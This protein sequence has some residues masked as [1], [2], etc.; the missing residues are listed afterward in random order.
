MIVSFSDI[1]LEDFDEIAGTYL[2]YKIFFSF[3]SNSKMSDGFLS[4]ALYNRIGEIGCGL[5]FS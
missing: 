3:S 1:W 2:F 5:Q 4:R